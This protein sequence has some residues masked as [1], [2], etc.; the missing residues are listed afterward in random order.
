[1]YKL[2]MNWLQN[3][4]MFGKYIS[5]EQFETKSHRKGTGNT[6]LEEIQKGANV[7]GYKCEPDSA[8]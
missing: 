5:V 2:C 6:F 1:M 8:D 3:T 4:P 7:K